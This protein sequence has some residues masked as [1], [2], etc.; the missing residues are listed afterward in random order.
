[1]RTQR[2]CN[3]CG[4]KL[5]PEQV[6]VYKTNIYCEDCLM[7]LGLTKRQCDPW[8]LTKETEIGEGIK[9]N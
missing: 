2:E 5:T 3:H 8:R 1:M 7:K 4:L 9:S 6:Y